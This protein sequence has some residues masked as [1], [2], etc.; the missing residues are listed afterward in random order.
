MS[1]W[2]PNLTYQWN[3]GY[4]EI[5]VIHT[6]CMIYFCYWILRMI[7]WEKINLTVI[8]FT[9]SYNNIISL[10][11]INEFNTA[12]YNVPTETTLYC[13]GDLWV[14]YILTVYKIY[15]NTFSQIFDPWINF[16]MT[17]I[18]CHF[19]TYLYYVKIIKWSCI[20]AY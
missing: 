15:C 7:L 14:Y 4:K 8:F 3:C 6:L 1:K 17:L 10:W 16:K 20:I 11:F 9:Y 18:L 5:C 12:R 2:I 19:Y 13:Y